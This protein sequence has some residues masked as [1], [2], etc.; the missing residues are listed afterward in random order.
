MMILLVAGVTLLGVLGFAL[1]F[2]VNLPDTDGPGIY[3]DHSMAAVIKIMV[4]T[5]SMIVYIVMLIGVTY[6]MT[7]WLGIH[8][9]RTM[10]S[11][12]GYL[13]Q[14]LPVSARQ[15]IVS[16]TLVAGIWNMLL[17]LSV[18]LSIGILAFSLMGLSIGTDMLWT[19]WSE[20]IREFDELVGLLSPEVIHLL[21]S[22]LIMCLIAPFSAVL[23]LFGSL[24]IGQLSNKYKAVMGI[25]AYFGVLFAQ[26]VL[27][28]IIQ[29][30]ASLGG[31]FIL[32]FTEGESMAMGITYDGS[33][34]LMLIMGGAMYFIMHY[35]LTRRLN[36]D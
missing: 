8:F 24:T 17:S 23:V 6:G 9:Y 27:N 28:Y 30:I 1:P 33:I 15:L 36:M 4:M 5:I 22:L 31:A 25:L 26:M 11:D 20:I 7:I 2:H 32:S 35:I 10:Y 18:M 14:T 34:L 3:N 13:T 21:V 19:A 29:F 16:K 12:E